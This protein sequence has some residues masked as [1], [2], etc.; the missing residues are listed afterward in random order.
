MHF[1]RRGQSKQ[2]ELGIG[3]RLGRH[4]DLLFQ[5]RERLLQLRVSAGLF[6][7]RLNLFPQFACLLHRGRNFSQSRRQF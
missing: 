4:F 7:A 1:P 2:P 5:R 3:I 6:L